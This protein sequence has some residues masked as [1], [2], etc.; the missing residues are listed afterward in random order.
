MYVVV[1]YAHE[2]QNSNLQQQIS[3]IYIQVC[4][5]PQINIYSRSSQTG[6]QCEGGGST[7]TSS[8]TFFLTD[9]RLSDGTGKGMFDAIK[10]EL[11]KRANPLT[12]GFGLGTD[13]ATAMTGT[14]KRT[15]WTVLHNTLLF[16]YSTT[17]GGVLAA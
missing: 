2:V 8:K 10:K 7:D 16:F 1:D 9:V 6:Y 5:N 13:S 3:V 17:A 12:R 15:D 14:K 4:I 11:D